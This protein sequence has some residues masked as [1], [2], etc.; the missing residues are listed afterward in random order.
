MGRKYTED[1]L[2]ELN[3][4]PALEN[5]PTENR[6]CTDV[7]CLLIFLLFWAATFFISATTYSKGKLDRVMRPVDYSGN[8][9]LILT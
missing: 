5:G 7:I 2:R 3:I 9:N 6:K 4:D 1:D 8:K